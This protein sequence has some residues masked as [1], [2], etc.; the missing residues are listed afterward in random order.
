LQDVLDRGLPFREQVQLQGTFATMKAGTKKGLAEFME[1]KSFM[2]TQLLKK[3]YDGWSRLLIRFNGDICVASIGV[4]SPNR[5]L[6]G[7]PLQSLHD[8]TIPMQSLFCGIDVTPEGGAFIFSWRTE[9]EAPRTFVKSLLKR[10]TNKLPTLLVQFLFAYIENTVFSTGWWES[11]SEFNR[12]QLTGLAGISNPYYTD[13]D[14]SAIRVV[15]WQVT[16]IVTED[17]V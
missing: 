16:D 5:D 8:L 10:S 17:P 7:N 9:H 4:V 11:L 15:P 1:Q 13:L 3:D 14:F 12:E 6:D 2:D